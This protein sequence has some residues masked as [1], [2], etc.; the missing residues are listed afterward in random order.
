MLDRSRD[1]G[2]RLRALR[3]RHERDVLELFFGEDLVPPADAAD[4]RERQP[5]DADDQVRDQ[6][7]TD[8]RQPERDHHR[9]HGGRGQ[10]VSV[11]IRFAHR[12]IR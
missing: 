3:D 9:P 12:P 6:R 5:D 8:Q 4:Q 11:R 7:G 1:T 10:R 2:D